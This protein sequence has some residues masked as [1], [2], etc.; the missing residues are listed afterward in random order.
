QRSLKFC[1]R[2]GFSI[3][4]FLVIVLPASLYLTEFVFDDSSFHIWIWF[5]II[6]AFVAAGIIIFL[7]IIEARKNISEIFHKANMNSEMKYNSDELQLSEDN[8]PVMKILV[9]ID[10]S[11]RS[12]KAL[13][14]A[15]Y[16]FRG[17]AKVRIYLLHVIEWTDEN[18]ENIDEELASQIQEEGK[19]IL[20]SVVLPRQIN[21]YKRIVKLGDPAEKIS[22]L[23]DKLKV[24]MIIMDKKG[25][26]KSTSDLGSVT[27]KVLSLTSK[28]VVLLD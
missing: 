17:A 20:R 24:D 6:W 18:E 21:D 5:A 11:A 22:E 12:L 1:K 14:H 23:A 13:Y 7:P 10:G 16:L 8:S 28:P 15:N 9:P 2:A 19:L 26:G 3:S 4:V 27:K 25:L